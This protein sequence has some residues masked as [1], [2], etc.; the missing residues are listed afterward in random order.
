MVGGVGGGPTGVAGWP[1]GQREA[2]A[3]LARFLTSALVI[4]D[5]GQIGLMRYGWPVLYACFAY[6][7]PDRG[8][9]A[10]GGDAKRS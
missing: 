8:H 5:R 9:R 6:F 2:A 1:A 4:P 7:I 10:N 3:A